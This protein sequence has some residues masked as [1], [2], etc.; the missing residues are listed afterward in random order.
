M[1]CDFYSAYNG[2]NAKTQRCHT[3][4]L[5]ELHVTAARSPAFAASP[6]R[7]RCRRLCKDML[8]LKTRKA[9]LAPAVYERRVV[10]LEARLA[11]LARTHSDDPDVKRLVK[12]LRRH[13]KELTPFLRI[14]ALD[15]TNNAAER[16][17]RPVVVGRKISGGFRS[18]PAAR[19][20]MVLTS[21]IR[22]AHQQGRAV[23]ST[24]RS[25]LTKAWA[26]DRTPELTPSG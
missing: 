20:S 19:A 12:R 3:H 5:R 10:R 6:F 2:M 8:L 11:E 22:A 23:L 9:A 1:G 24:I 13:R 17:I 25:I 21:I 7:R 18:E 16:A 26:G 4:L 14:D 15:G